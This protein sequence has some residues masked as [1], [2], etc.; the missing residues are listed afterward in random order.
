M[1]RIR[2]GLWS[3]GAEHRLFCLLCKYDAFAFIIKRNDD[4]HHPT[5]K[6][7]AMTSG[8]AAFGTSLILIL[9]AVWWIFRKPRTHSPHR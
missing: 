3:A 4:V 1:R 2:C 9:C 8:L 7:N 5:Q 6:G